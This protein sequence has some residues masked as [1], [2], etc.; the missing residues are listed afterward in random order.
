[1]CAK[2]YFFRYL[3]RID[4]DKTKVV[5]EGREKRERR[6]RGKLYGLFSW[7]F[8]WMI[9]MD[10]IYCNCWLLVVLLVRVGNVAYIL[11]STRF[12]MLYRLLPGRHVPVLCLFIDRSYQL[13]DVKIGRLLSTEVFW[14][15]RPYRSLVSETNKKRSI[16]ISWPGS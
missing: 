9:E 2:I 8:V 11:L 4:D 3:Q 14:T 10:R 15:L 5:K 12:S 16:L 7:I 1:M 13:S 6:R